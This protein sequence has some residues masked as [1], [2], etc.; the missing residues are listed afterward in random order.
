[1]EPVL[2]QA[3]G[4]HP[5]C[6]CTLGQ[7]V[8]VGPGANGDRPTAGLGRYPS[9]LLAALVAVGPEGAARGRLIRMVWDAPMEPRTLGRLRTTLSRLRGVLAAGVGA[10]DVVV[11]VPPSRLR[12][13]ELRARVDAWDLLARA[14]EP[15]TD[16]E[17][18]LAV[19]EAVRGPFAAGQEGAAWI[20]AY[21]ICCREA[22]EALA[23]HTVAALSARGRTEE[24]GRLALRARA[25]LARER[26]AAPVTP[27]P[28]A[29][30]G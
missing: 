22:Y 29:T 25:V 4:T 24:A 28:P 20:D 17:P 3:R 26:A 23:E 5:C 7:V 13:N 12:L 1:M 10:P 9:R 15:G 27:S 8:V 14:A 16:L 2:S 21:R 11:E 30:P 18:G 6:V 19:L